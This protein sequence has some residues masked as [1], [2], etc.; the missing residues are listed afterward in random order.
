MEFLEDESLRSRLD[1]GPIPARKVIDYATQVA[2]GPA[3]AREKRSVR[4]PSTACLG[5]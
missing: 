5:R 1:A 3:A 4:G 2:H